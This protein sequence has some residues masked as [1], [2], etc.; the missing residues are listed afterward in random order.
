MAAA[1]SGTS[2]TLLERCPEICAV[3]VLALGRGITLVGVMRTLGRA[4]LPTYAICDETDFAVRSRWYH[5]PPFKG[6]LSLGPTELAT[7]LQALPLTDAVL[8]PC[9][10]DWVKAV[11]ALP[12]SL[13]ARYPSSV[14]SERTI[15]K[16]VDKWQFAQLLQSLGIPHPRTILIVS[17]AQLESL[18]ASEFGTQILKPL[19]S[20]EFLR[21][22]GV[23]GYL[24]TSSE[25]AMQIAT[26]IQF[27]IM[28]QEYVPGAPSASYFID[29]FVDRHGVVCARFARR[30]LR[31]YPPHL[32]NSSLMV[33]I[34]LEQV[35]G[36]LEDLDR[37]LAAVSYRGIFSAEF[38]YDSRDE[39]FKI[40]EINARPWWYIEFAAR[41]GVDVCRL[42]YLDALERP[43]KPVRNYKV[44]RHCILL[45]NDLRAYG[46][47]RRNDGATL[48]SWIRSCIGADDALFAWNDPLPWITDSRRV[49][50]LLLTRQ[51]HRAANWGTSRFRT[52]PT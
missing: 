34:P 48:R 39:Q 43:I 33:S 17:C 28:L 41:C 44:G 13:A 19:S 49:L 16:M 3:P 22:H 7:F 12:R 37:L 5:R 2:P 52:L 50:T 14:G 38:K 8:M 29:G 51:L 45:S 21:S 40:I 6:Q 23:K 36:A 30:R 10:D 47:M 4:N 1:S 18:S 24:V 27:P 25:E 46:E 15:G 20:R 32:G 35:D 11:A 31:M 26:R 9:A 42:A